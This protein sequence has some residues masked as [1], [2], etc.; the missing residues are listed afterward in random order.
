M[1]RSRLGAPRRRANARSALWAF[2]CAGARGDSDATRR[3]IRSARRAGWPR[4][5]LEEAG[6]MLVL[7]AGYPAALEALRELLECWPARVRA[8]REGG[9]ASWRRRGRRL[10]RSVYGEV[11]ARLI[12]SVAARHPDLAVWVEE[13][14]YGRVLSRPG[15]SLLD[16]ELVTVAVL[17]QSGWE[18]QLVSHMLGAERV[19]GSRAE[20]RRAATLGVRAGGRSGS[21]PRA[22]L[23]RRAWAH[24]FPS[25]GR[26]LTA[27][28]RGR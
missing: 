28:E 6:L 15:L 5:A 19:G 11:H 24:A 26:A 14:G 3:A 10:C 22:A 4:R 13:H 27:R 12:A 17:A 20:I 21:A 25:G 18:R 8:A 2:A 1:P 9:R 23:S 16:R 7:Y